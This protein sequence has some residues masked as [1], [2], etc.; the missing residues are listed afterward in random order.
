MKEKLT[1]LDLAGFRSFRRV[2]TLELRDLNVLIGANGSGKPN[3]LDFFQMLNYMMSESLELYVGRKGG[4][5]SLLHFGPRRTPLMEATLEFTGRDRVSRYEFQ[6]TRADPDRLL[7][8]A[9]RVEFHR[10][11]DPRPYE[12]SLGAGRFESKL[13]ELAKYKSERARN[14]VARVFRNRLT[15]VRAF[16]FHDTSDEAHIRLTQE[17]ERNRYLM[18]TGG[19]LAA[20]L[21]RLAETHPQHYRNIVDTVRMVL[22]FL[23]EF[24]LEPDPRS[25]GR[26]ILLRWLSENP[27]YEFG[28]HQLPDGGLRVLR[29]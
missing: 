14:R 27:E 2:E 6:L 23:R 8:T 5:S 10:F 16:H 26:Y 12:E 20:F 21:L 1:H 19:N 11:R 17:V 18:S 29:S 7:Y 13:P 25:K 28:P 22:P 4:A 24:V 9:E 3:F 15:D